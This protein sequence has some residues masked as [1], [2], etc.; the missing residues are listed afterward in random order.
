MTASDAQGGARRRK[1][2]A[3]SRAVTTGLA[4]RRTLHRRGALVLVVGV[5]VGLPT[6]EAPAKA[7]PA[8]PTPPVTRPPPMPGPSDRGLTMELVLAQVDR[9]LA[10]R[11]GRFA[12]PG[13]L[14]PAP[15]G[16]P[17]TRAPYFVV[18]AAPDRGTEALP[19]ESTRAEVHVAGVIAGVRLTQVYR[20]RGRLPI[21]ALYVFPLSPRAAVH[22][23]RLRAGGRTV[24]ARI[25]SRPEA[26]ERFLAARRQGRRAAL[27][28]EERRSLLALRVTNLLPGE[29]V[30]VELSYSELLLPE[31]GEYELVI[32][33]VAGPLAAARD[34]GPIPRW[35]L[36]PRLPEGQG[37][38]F[39]LD[40]HLEA[41]V[42]LSALASPSHPEAVT[43]PGPRE[44][45]VSFT[46]PAGEAR[47]FVLR[48]RLTGTG[49]QAGAL[50]HAEGGEQHFLLLV[51]PPAQ[52]APASLPPREVLF[53]LD[54][55]GS[56][57]GFP[58]RTAQAL[59]RK[60][61]AT[62]R[63]QDRFNL[64][65]FAG[66]TQVLSP[67]S[68]PATASLLEQAL[69]LA[70]RQHGAGNTDLLGALKEAYSL[71]RPEAPGL[72]RSV[73][74]ITD[75]Y[76]ALQAE[77][78]RFIRRRLPEA[79]C[80]VFGIGQSVDRALIQGLAR[81]GRGTPFVVAGA[82]EAAAAADRLHRQLSS[83]VLTGLRA[84]VEGAEA[85]DLVP[86]ALPDLFAGR[87]LVLF[88]KLQGGPGRILVTGHTGAAP[89][90]LTVPLPT[91]RAGATTRPLRALWARAWAEE[92]SD[93]RAML[94]GDPGLVEALGRL[95]VHYGLLTPVTGFVAVDRV[96]NP[97]GTV[98]EVVQPLAPAGAREPSF[99][100]RLRRLGAPPAGDPDAAGG[101]AEPERVR[102]SLLT[103]APACRRRIG[104]CGC[105][106][107]PSGRDGPDAPGALLLLSWLLF[108][109]LL[110]PRLRRRRGGR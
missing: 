62:L 100:D 61:F 43:R 17:T 54:V 35:L 80:F 89:F 88:G 81:A 30:E 77:T 41:P 10:A 73:V 84:Q 58:L 92:L 102:R 95:G 42:P 70:G 6:L 48:Y 46:T 63:P 18:P 45:R 55:S 106:A 33:A 49:I 93:Q 1:A 97:T 5:L 32:P 50:T 40:L 66:R 65:L 87:P 4:Q 16:A 36:P 23:L 67:A 11:P 26:T 107:A 14:P 109:W 29:R 28:L 96:V 86:E 85:Y 79:N 44:A 59:L 72:S 24:E 34:L 91:P 22:G 9:A 20:N 68:L 71:P 94:P 78:F 27:L 76:V 51:T 83:P 12:V 7:R 47:N 105:D 3:T 98:T 90:S 104:G 31:E 82:S 99:L 103:A 108:S 60:L 15:L 2:P 25:A 74:V 101:A 19:L 52:P 110:L 69:A 8:P 56:M 38:P 39:S 75:G 57:A 37:T 64:V 13:A 53:V 21:E